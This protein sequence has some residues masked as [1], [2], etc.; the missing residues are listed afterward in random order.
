MRNEKIV[1]ESRRENEGQ[2]NYIN[3]Q[4]VGTGKKHKNERKQKK[5]EG[6]GGDDGQRR[7]K[8]C[9]C[10]ARGGNARCKS[11]TSNCLLGGVRLEGHRAKKIGKPGERPGAENRRITS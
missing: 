7:R 11:D 2:G 5:K 6:D 9:E 8:E 1:E 3:N 10:R 4:N